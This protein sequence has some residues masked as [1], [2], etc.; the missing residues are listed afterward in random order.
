MLAEPS[1]ASARLYART[2]GLAFAFVLLLATGP[3]APIAHAQQN[4]VVIGG[5]SGGVIVDLS[6]L[7]Q[8][9][10]AGDDAGDLRFPG[11][12]L[13]PNDAV[14]LHRLGAKPQLR[15]PTQKRARRPAK[16]RTLAKTKQPPRV[17]AKPAPIT[18]PNQADLPAPK[19]QVATPPPKPVTAPPRM[20]EMARGTVP[21]PPP[22][23][24]PPAP[25][26][27]S[28]MTKAIPDVPPVVPAPRT[29]V[30]KSSLIPPAPPPAMPKKTPEQMA[31]RPTA[32]EKTDGPVGAGTTRM[33]AFPA[34]ATTVPSG[35]ESTLKAAALAL[36]GNQGLRVQL[37]A[38][39][40]SGKDGESRAR[41]LS[42]TRALGVRSFLIKQGVE[43]TR[44][45]VRA[46]GSKVPSGSADRV[47]LSVVAR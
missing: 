7:D 6:A 17:T 5:E 46:L 37:K 36:K 27:A 35:A 18:V 8:F 41:R 43:P 14:R 25:P 44:I 10:R 23:A 29:S 21:P 33:I 31:S 15:R 12:R 13:G 3:I 26:A 19:P 20:P 45:D 4:T 38:Y 39:A 2:L 24:Q 32:P 11:A 34:G 22:P 9:G 40:A 30:A 1:T 42:L 28:T 47:D 16:K